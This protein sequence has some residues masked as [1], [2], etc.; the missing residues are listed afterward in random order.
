MCAELRR[1]RQA[2]SEKRDGDPP[3]GLNHSENPDSPPLVCTL[4]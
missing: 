3:I 1:L 4:L 2:G